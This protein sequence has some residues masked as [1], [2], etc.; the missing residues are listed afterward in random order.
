[1]LKLNKKI[2]QL[3]KANQ[4]DISEVEISPLNRIG[5]NR[6]FIAKTKAK[7]FF[8]KHYFQSISD[9]RDRF[10]SE[11]AFYDYASNCTNNLIPKVIAC[12]K[13]SRIIIFDYIKGDNFKNITLNKNH[14]NQAASF[15]SLL[16]N[17]NFKSKF[18]NK[19]KNGSESCFS[20]KSH[21]KFT[22]NKICY[23]EKSINNTAK[24][25]E[26]IDLLNDLNECFKKTKKQ[27]INFSKNNNI[28]VDEEITLDKRII[29]PSDFGFH[30]C[31]INKNKKLIFFDF[32]YS[33]LDDPAKVIGDFF[34]QLEIPVPITFFD[35]FVDKAFVNFKNK[36]EMI[37]RSKLLFPLF[38]IKWACIVLNVFLPVNL[39][40]RLFSNPDID[41]AEY[42]SN[43]LLKAQIIIKK[44][45]I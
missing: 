4:D 14:I 21:L 37:L 33:G 18:G 19:I 45:K 32:E 23:L 16:N 36:D 6:T 2:V 40:R 5:N 10:G 11:I 13:L 24:N 3:L 30:N 34:S 15:F 29:S 20:I 43:Q 8:I 27:I 28:N 41:I 12:D 9:N 42:K 22:K 25:K 35:L 31:I 44:F 38:K 1:M 26:I 17:P 39:E 7:T